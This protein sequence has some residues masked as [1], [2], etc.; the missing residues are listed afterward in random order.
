MSRD[1]GMARISGK[2]RSQQKSLNL[3]VNEEG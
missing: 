2:K 1:N 3:P